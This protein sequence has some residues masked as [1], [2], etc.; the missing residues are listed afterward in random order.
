M[1]KK[2]GWLLIFCA[3]LGT[4][5]ELFKIEFPTVRFPFTVSRNIGLLHAGTGDDIFPWFGWVFTLLVLVA[6][7]WM[8]VHF[9]RGARFT[10]ITLRRIHPLVKLKRTHGRRVQERGKAKEGVKRRKERRSAS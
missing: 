7:I 4:V 9:A 6:G 3:A 8:S 10:P 5:G 1:L 2:L